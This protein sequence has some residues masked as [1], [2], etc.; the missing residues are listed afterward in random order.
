M[1]WDLQTSGPI[2]YIKP[3]WFCNSVTYSECGTMLGGYFL[4]S[5]NIIIYNILSETQIFSH[6]ITKCITGDIWTHDGHLQYTIVNPKS[7]TIWEVSFTS[8]HA[9]IEVCTLQTPDNFPESE[10]EALVFFPTLSLLAFTLP[11]KIFVWDAQGQKILLDSDAT[12]MDGWISF[13]PDGQFFI[14]ETDYSEFCLYKKSPDGYLPHQKLVPSVG[15]SLLLT[16]PDG[17]SII[18]SSGLALQLWHTNYLLSLQS[19]SSPAQQT[20]DA[21]LEFLPDEPSVAIAESSEAVTILD[22]KSGNPQI[23]IDVGME[24]CGMEIIGGKIIVVG[25]ERS[26]IWELPT[27]NHTFGTK[28]NVG[29]SIRTIKFNGKL[30]Y[31]RI[32]ISPNLDYM[33][34]DHGHLAILDMYTGKELG[35]VLS[36][37]WLPGFAL[38]GKNIWYAH[39]GGGVKLWEIV[40]SNGGVELKDFETIEPLIEFPWCSPH[41]YQITDDGWVFSS[42]GKRLLW[43]PHLW[44]ADAKIQRKWNGKILALLHDGL[45]EVV[46][47]E[48]KV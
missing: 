8:G 28:W 39:S 22:L 29:H 42:S 9:P 16:S 15:C 6:S 45:P 30:E 33:V 11:G 20:Q 41:G 23:V 10:P 34:G 47:L 13:S 32:S 5:R 19:I 2:S 43:L 44:R 17:G 3:G 24:V 31:H 38:D 12:A 37:G 7:I 40:K 35:I 48:F 25:S 36:V 21:Y 14:Y 4:E 18:S 1:S 26:I 27:G 46:I